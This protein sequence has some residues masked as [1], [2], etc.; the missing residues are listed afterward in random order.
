M[1]LCLD[2]LALGSKGAF[3]SAVSCEKAAVRKLL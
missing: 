1:M 2:F 3:G